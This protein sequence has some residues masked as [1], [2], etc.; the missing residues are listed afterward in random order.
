MPSV[1][2]NAGSSAGFFSAACGAVGCVACAGCLAGLWVGVEWW[3]WRRGCGV[4]ALPTPPYPG[5]VVGRV[6]FSGPKACCFGTSCPLL[7]TILLPHLQV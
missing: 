4:T 3:V 2:C 6:A 7:V 5:T 1:S